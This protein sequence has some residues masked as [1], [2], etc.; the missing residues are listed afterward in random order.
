MKVIV[1]CSA[2]KICI[3]LKIL[4]QGT[5]TLVGI[6]QLK[7]WKKKHEKSQT[8]KNGRTQ[9]NCD[10]WYFEIEYNKL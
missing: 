2:E 4:R 3:E 6:T 1:P 9:K 7:I 5:F 8:P 10:Y